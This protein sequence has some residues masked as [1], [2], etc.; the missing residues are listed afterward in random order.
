MSQKNTL[1]ISISLNDLL[2]SRLDDLAERKYSNRSSILRAALAE[3]L[4]K[5]ANAPIGT[6][7][8]IY[9]DILAEHPLVDPADTELL[10]ILKNVKDNQH[11]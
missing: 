3:Y 11:D 7:H 4:D 9:A 2:L 8:I 10:E 5:P 6:N 1:K